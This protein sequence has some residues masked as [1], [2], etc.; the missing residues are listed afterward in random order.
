MIEIVKNL[1][2]REVEE[3]ISSPLSLQL[4]KVY[5]YLYLHGAQ[6]R[7]CAKSQRKYYQQLKING[8]ELATKYDKAMARTCKPRWRGL[9][10]IRKIAS[11]V[12]SENITDEQAIKYL[13]SGV[14]RSEDFEILP[15]T[16]QIEEIK[17]E[18]LP[19]DLINNE[20]PLVKIAPKKK[21]ISR[22]R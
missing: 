6:P 4:L 15:A 13:E 18:E 12:S 21:V 1:I 9:R 22:K 11:H 3:I 17:V 20:K 8:I 16:F 19:K 7:T 10:F 2:G 5:S 14:L